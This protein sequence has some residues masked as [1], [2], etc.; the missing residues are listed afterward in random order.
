LKDVLERHQQRAEDVKSFINVLLT[1][2]RY[3]CVTNSRHTQFLHCSAIHSSLSVSFS[4]ALSF[5]GAFSSSEFIGPRHDETEEEASHALLQAVDYRSYMQ[6]GEVIQPIFGLGV[7]KTVSLI[8]ELHNYGTVLVG[9]GLC[10]AYSVVDY[11]L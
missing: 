8:N 9:V 11:V 6:Y 7:E 2:F 1:Y 4:T 3:A 10:D 5:N